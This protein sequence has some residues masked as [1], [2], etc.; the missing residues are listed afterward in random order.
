MKKSILKELC[1]RNCDV[2]V[3]PYNTDA[4]SILE[5][6]PD[7]I[8]LSNGPGNPEELTESINTIKELSGKVPIFGICLGHQL[9]ALAQGAKTYKMLFGH[10][11]IYQ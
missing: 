1:L 4:N 10:R 2:V 5:L 9:Y 6:N 3:V 7:G 11:G 8:M